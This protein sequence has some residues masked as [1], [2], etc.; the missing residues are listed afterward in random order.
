MPRISDKTIRDVRDGISIVDV[1]SPYVDLKSVGRRYIGLSPFNA[2]KTPSFN[3]D[4]DKNFYYCFSSSKGG[5]NIS[6]IREV[7]NLSFYEAVEHLANRF[8]IQID[9]ED[10]GPAEPPS[11]RKEI[12]QIHDLAAEFFH[13]SLMADDQPAHTMRT[14]WTDQR[15]FTLTLAKDHRI[16]YAPAQGDQLLHQLNKHK[17][18]REAL[19]QCGLF[20]VNKRDGMPGRCR[21]RGR[22]MIPIRD[23]Q[24]RTVAFTARQTELTPRDIAYEDGKYVNSPDTPIFNKSRLLFGL[25]H[26]RQHIG[27]DEHA[28]I[29]VEGQLDAMR[30]WTVGLNT[31]IAP[32]GT[33]FNE[34]QVQLLRRYKPD[35]IDCLLD[36]D[37]AGRRAAL[38]YLPMFLA[39][40]LEAKFLLLPQGADPD[41]LIAQHGKDAIEQ[42]RSDSLG[43]IPFAISTL[44]PDPSNAS[45]QARAQVLREIFEILRACDL[46]TTRDAYLDELSR[47]MRI[48]TRAVKEDYEQFSTRQHR[49]TQSGTNQQ[50][51]L[52]PPK[53]GDTLTTAEDVLLLLLL[54][55]KHLAAAI[56][57]TVDEEWIASDTLSGRLLSR[58]VGCLQEDTWPGVKHISELLEDEEETNFV[59]ALL[60]KEITFEDQHDTAN[61]A[62]RKLVKRYHDRQKTHLDLELA[63]TPHN[64][65]ER[66]NELQ[67]Q[68]LQLRQSLQYSPTLPPLPTISSDDPTDA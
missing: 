39:A 26:A 30:C 12:H 41:D 37:S 61:A 43:A 63:N 60:H 10:G 64:D 44:L 49:R 21:F 6:F 36:G 23:V 7:E 5:D 24:G 31:A 28:F 56:A 58:F 15:R 11:L 19:A 8:N 22:L 16:G 65:A 55:N 34:E 66:I 45:P 51:Q 33:A 17:F 53:R 27:K 62:L 54:H 18:S 14:Y 20:F 50:N 46:A 29:L 48:D 68:R 59:Y 52:S 3:V 47:L 38:R 57:Q 25:H 42:L 1:V 40:G 13:Q 35:R 67:R 2:E 32:Q 4:P 9:Y